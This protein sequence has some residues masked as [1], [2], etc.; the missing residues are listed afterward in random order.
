MEQDLTNIRIG[1]PS[2]KYVVIRA[3]PEENSSVIGLETGEI[4]MTAD[5]NAESRRLVMNNP[6]LVY[7]EQSGI[8]V[9]YVGLNTTKGILKDRDVRR[10]IA[11]GID[12]DSIIDSILLGSV[13]KAN[14]FVAPGVFGYSAD[15]KTLEY[16]PEAAKKI[17]EQKGLKG[18]KLTIGVSN[19]PVRMQM[20]EI[21]QAQLKEIGLD[22]TVESLEWGA[23]LTAT[24]RGDLDM[25]SMGY[26]N[27]H[28]SQLGS[29]GN[30]SQYVNPKMDKLLDDAKKEINTEKRKELYKEVADIIYTDVPVIPMYYTNNTVASTK[31]IEGMKPTSY[32]RFNE[33]K[34]KV[35]DK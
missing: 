16:N 6:E 30:R 8:N 10:A 12:R 26:P 20:S 22:V 25:F 35:S 34:F 13:D 17:I 4:D 29:A 2:I 23:F 33:L 31:N 24:G 9:N 28:S 11:M 3:V 7:M 32:I 21:I 15:S 18:T 14:N 27:F 19:S 5:L 1:K